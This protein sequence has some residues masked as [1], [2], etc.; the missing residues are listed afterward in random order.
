MVGGKEII[1]GGWKNG[2]LCNVVEKYLVKLLYV[3]IWKV[4]NVII[5]FRVL[6]DKVLLES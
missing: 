6:G 2:N 4:E 5:E 1:I 3:I